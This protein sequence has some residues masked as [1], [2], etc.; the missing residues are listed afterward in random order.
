M[1]ERFKL[2][3]EAIVK[4]P[5]QDKNAMI[6]DLSV[7]VSYLAN[8]KSIKPRTLG[9]FSDI[10]LDELKGISRHSTRMDIVSDL[11]PDDYNL[12]DEIQIQ[13]GIGTQIMF[14]KQSIHQTLLQIF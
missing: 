6:V 1:T 5:I 14:T 7:V 2:I 10:V 8:R 13:R 9:E 12:K 3:P 4:R 11:Y